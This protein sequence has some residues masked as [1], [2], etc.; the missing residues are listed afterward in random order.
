MTV[1]EFRR[2][3]NRLPL[4]ADHEPIKVLDTDNVDVFDVHS[5]TYDEATHTAWINVNLEG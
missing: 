1:G 4:A 2:L 3:L 5:V